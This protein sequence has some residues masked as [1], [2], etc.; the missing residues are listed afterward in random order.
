M[1]LKRMAVEPSLR[2]AI[3]L[4]DKDLAAQLLKQVRPAFREPKA[5]Q[6]LHHVLA[7]TPKDALRILRAAKLVPPG[8]RRG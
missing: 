2:Q 4:W 3:A 8:L 5:P 1:L 7:M 6:V